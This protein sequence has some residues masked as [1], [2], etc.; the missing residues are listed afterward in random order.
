MQFQLACEE[1]DSINISIAYPILK[2][3]TRSK[4][5]QDKNSEHDGIILLGKKKPNLL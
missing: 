1:H 5:L 4:C 2:S 3:K